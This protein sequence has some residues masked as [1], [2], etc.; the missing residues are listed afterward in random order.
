MGSCYQAQVHR[1]TNKHSGCIGSEM[2]NSL[3]DRNIRTFKAKHPYFVPKK[4]DVFLFRKCTWCR[5]IPFISKCPV[6]KSHTNVQKWRL[7]IWTVVAREHQPSARGARKRKSRHPPVRWIP[8]CVLLAE[9]VPAEPV[10]SA[11]LAK[12]DYLRRPRLLTMAR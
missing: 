9:G 11:E 5:D 10:E 7:S 1:G 8:G 4:S 3:F 2:R 6:V 12:L